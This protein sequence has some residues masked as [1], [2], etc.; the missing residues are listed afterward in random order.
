MTARVIRCTFPLIDVAQEEITEIGLIDVQGYAQPGTGIYLPVH[1]TTLPKYI[2]RTTRTSGVW[3][4]MFFIGILV[5]QKDDALCLLS[6]D[7]VGGGI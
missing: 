4:Y 3:R 7:A 1:I 6:T 5:A 2:R